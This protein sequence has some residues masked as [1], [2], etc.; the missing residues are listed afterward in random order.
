ML[1]EE[2]MHT[3][4]GYVKNQSQGGYN[5]CGSATIEI[6]PLWGNKYEREMEILGWNS[7]LAAKYLGKTKTQKEK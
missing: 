5:K 4:V 3:E 7:P 6:D 2:M 1:N